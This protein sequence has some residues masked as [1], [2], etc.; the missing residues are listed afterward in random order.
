[1][2]LALSQDK[3]LILVTE[4]TETTIPL[5]G[6]AFILANGDVRATPVDKSICQASGSCDDVVVEIQSFSSSLASENVITVSEGG[7]FT[8]GWRSVGATSCRGTGTYS[9]W[10]ER[11]EL[12]T[13]S[14]LVANAS[15]LEVTT[16]SGDAAGSPYTLGMECIN[17]SVTDNSSTQLTLVVEEVV[18]PS[19]TSCV[20]R[21]PIS[22]WTRLTT[23]SLSCREASGLDTNADCRKWSPKLWANPFLGS[24]GISE[25]VLTNV[26]AKR[27]YVAIEFDTNGM[28][29]T[30]SGRLSTESPGAV[31]NSERLLATIS[32]CPGD[33][34]P[35][36][37]TGC[38]ISPSAFS[39]FT[40][41]GPDSGS[42]SSCVLQ[43]NETYYLN[44]LSTNSPLGTAP[45]A[46]EPVDAC[47]NNKCGVLL[48][49]RF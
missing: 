46:I 24:G 21:E 32:K 28:A 7:K 35:S 31:I 13:D 15:E 16:S 2:S 11:A 19:P 45:S 34:N 4:P 17:G 25:R 20:G 43:P 36:Q 14:R 6:S 12:I 10:A 8:V 1:M 22:G 26:S 18:A 5:V 40:W 23:G 48:T 41:R 49:P 47:D 38:Y 30:A 27:Q 29:G 3:S 33:F 9:P 44:I 39:Q 37:V 42:T